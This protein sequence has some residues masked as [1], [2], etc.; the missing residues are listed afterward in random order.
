MTR[1][2]NHLT[3]STIFCSILVTITST[4]VTV[5]R[6]V[7][8][9]GYGTVIDVPATM[10]I[11]V[12]GEVNK[13]ETRDIQVLFIRDKNPDAIGIQINNLGLTGSFLMRQ[14]GF[15]IRGSNDEGLNNYDEMRAAFYGPQLDFDGDGWP[16]QIFIRS[17]GGGVI[18]SWGPQHL[19]MTFS[20]PGVAQVPSPRGVTQDRNVN[21][22]AIVRAAWE[23]GPSI[24]LGES[25]VSSELDTILDATDPPDPPTKP[26]GEGQLQFRSGDEVLQNMDTQVVIR[27]RRPL[28]LDLELVDSEG[29][30]SGGLLL[31]FPGEGQ[32]A[33]GTYVVAAQKAIAG[34]IQLT[35]SPLEKHTLEGAGIVTIRNEGDRTMGEISLPLFQV[36]GQFELD[37]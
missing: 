28:Q 6:E 10:T 8:T 29:P 19:E 17:G 20:F 27:G 21:V 3:V 34:R 18:N 26:S 36:T 9:Y 1:I 23:D 16:D 31:K 24:D 14:G 30:Q 5:A 25:S 13:S 2:R 4:S 35:L 11:D 32:P 22:Q 37:I 12:N 7:R 15:T 33:P